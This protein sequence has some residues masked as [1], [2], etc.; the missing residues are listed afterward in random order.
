[1]RKLSIHNRLAPI[2][3]NEAVSQ[4]P[5]LVDLIKKFK[6]ENLKTSNV[7][8]SS[9][10]IEDHRKYEDSN[11]VRS[12]SKQK[13]HP[14]FKET[15]TTLYGQGFQQRRFNRKPSKELGRTVGR[16][17]LTTLKKSNSILSPW[18]TIT[19]QYFVSQSP[20]D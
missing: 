9:N 2:D 7:N 18:G 16:G 14:F 1:V 5:S 8:S 20:A 13:T 11:F 10:S 4:K 12:H 3:F 19:D 15:T 6:F 17:N